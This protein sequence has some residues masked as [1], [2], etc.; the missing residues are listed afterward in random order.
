[1]HT[2]PLSLMEPW[3]V[4]EGGSWRLTLE[5]TNDRQKLREQRKKEEN[6]RGAVGRRGCLIHRLRQVPGETTITDKNKKSALSHQPGCI[7][8]IL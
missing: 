1:M 3:E 5:W 2:Q 7:D 4:F 6:K 8:S